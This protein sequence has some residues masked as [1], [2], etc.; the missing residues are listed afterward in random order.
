MINYFL[1]FPTQ[2]FKDIKIL[3]KYKCLLI[4]DPVYFT[5]Y[6]FHKSKLL[7]H[8]A[9]MKAYYDFLKDKDID[10]KYIDYNKP[11]MDIFKTGDT[12]T[13]YDPEDFDLT[14]KLARTSARILVLDN[15]NFLLDSRG[16]QA[17]LSEIARTQKLKNGQVPRHFLH[18]ASFY[19]WIRRYLNI[20]M[21]G[22]K[23]A[24]DKWTFDS[25]NRKPFP[26]NTKEPIK[27]KIYKNKYYDEAA[28]YVNMH[29]GAN[30]GAVN[31]IYPVTFADTCAVVKSFIK[32]KLALFGPYEDAIGQDINVGYHSGLSAM[33]N[34]GLIMPRDL[35]K[36]VLKVYDVADLKQKR[37][38][39]T[40][41]EGFIRQV[42]GWREYMRLLYRIHGREIKT[43]NYFGNTG[44]LSREWF[45]ATTANVYKN[46]MPIIYDMI[47]KTHDRAYLHH[48]ERLMVMGNF[49]LYNEINPR[50]IYDWYMICFIDAYDWVMMANVYGMSQY[51][52]EGMSMTQRPYLCGS[53]YLL[54][55]SD[56]K[57]GPWC[58]YWDALFYNFVNKH[59]AKLNKYR[60]YLFVKMY[61]RKTSEQK[62]KLKRGYVDITNYK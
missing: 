33:L 58:E 38:L 41:V 23:P 60:T 6:P 1:I 30:F 19:R 17:Y 25:E 18:D 7:F 44:K 29:F 14:S 31:P 56:Y 2:L 55:M 59:R 54:K 49:A 15:P 39:I 24:F 3:T 8:R 20:L 53:S 46:K 4:E 21:D 52:L 32:N 10:V 12:I 36:E 26:K 28:D 16:I 11:Y 45:N 57:K 40:S 35:I 43:M 13:Y 34:V 61:D 42:I 62:N 9:S 5:K 51:A 50:E 48:I 27:D 22:S 47:K 37:T